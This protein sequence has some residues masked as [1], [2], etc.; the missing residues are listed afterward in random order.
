MAFKQKHDQNKLDR[1]AVLTKEI[2]NQLLKHGVI[3]TDD[4]DH[5]KHTYIQDTIFWAI[6]KEL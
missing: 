4:E 3:P 6:V 1:S 5:L 2:M